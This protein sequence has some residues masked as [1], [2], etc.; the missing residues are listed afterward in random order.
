VEFE[1]PN[2]FDGEGA[3]AVDFAGGLM[4]SVAVLLTPRCVALMEA[5]VTAL[6][7][8]VEML[9]VAEV[10]PASTWTLAGTCALD[11]ELD[12]GTLIPPDCA[13]PFR[14]TVP[15]EAF[16]PIRVRGATLKDVRAAG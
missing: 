16:P 4:V 13:G 11:F 3:T 8:D 12:K 6:T 7:T 14:I 2:N 9:N 1:P 5:V 10:A 15:M